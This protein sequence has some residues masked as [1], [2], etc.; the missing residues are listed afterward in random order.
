[1]HAIEA[2]LEQKRTST[3]DD[4]ETAASRLA[5]R[6]A[7]SPD[8]EPD[9]AYLDR[10]SEYEAALREARRYFLRMVESEQ[11]I[12]EAGE[13]LLDNFYVIQQAA[14]QV[15]ENLPAGYYRR[16]PVWETEEGQGEPRVYDLACSLL[17]RTDALLDIERIER[18][19]HAYQETKTLTMGEL[20]A[21]PTIL[22]LAVLELLARSSRRL[23]EGLAEAERASAPPP[24]DAPLEAVV[25]RCVRSLHVIET[26]DWKA[27]FEEASRVEGVLREDPAGVYAGMDFETRDAYRQVVEKL[28]RSS[29]RDEESVAREALRLAE[30]AEGN[31]GLRRAAHIGFYL[32]GRG[33]RQLETRLDYRPAWR[34]RPRRW[35]LERPLPIYLGAIGLLTLLILAG[36][37]AYAHAAGGTPVG[38]IGA[39][40]LGLAPALAA[41]V[42]LVNALVTR[43]VPPRTLPKLDL[44]EGV[45]AEQTT[46]VVIPSML[47][48]A[49]E[50]E[51]LLDQL[52][53]HYL[54]NVDPHLHFALLTDWADAPEEHMPGD[55]E[56]V[57]QA[58]EGIRALNGKYRREGAGPFYLFHRRRR[59][60]PGESS[61]MGWERKRGKL[62]EFNR[63]LLDRG[64]TSYTVQM[65]DLEIL[66]EI[67]Y[68][69]TLDADTV[70]PRDSARRLIATLAHPLNRPVFAPDGKTVTAG[71]TVL[72]PRVEVKPTAV[73]RSRFTRIFAGDAGVDLYTRA[74]SDVYHDLFGEGIYVGKGIY[75]VETFQHSLAGRVPDNTILSHDLFEGIQGR[76]GLVS[77]VILYED[78]PPDYLSYMRRLH[79]WVRGDW[80]LLPWLLP[81]A[82]HA[83]GSKVPN[84][85]SLLDRWKIV[86]NLRRSLHA[87]ALLLWLLVG[88][89][90]LPGSSLAWT[91]LVLLISA[92]SL[93]TSLLTNAA[94][95]LVNGGTSETGSSLKTEA[96]RWLLSLVFLPYEALLMIDA[97]G[98]T[99]VRMLVSRKRLLQW[100]TAAHTIRLFGREKKL[101]IIWRQ[102]QSAVLL[103]LGLAV[104]VGVARPAALSTAA[105]FLLAWLASPWVAL[106][107]SRSIARKR[108]ELSAE[109]RNRLRRLARRTWLY[110]ERFIGPEDHWL[111]P[112]H[113][114]EDPRGV[115][116]HRTSPT[117]IGLALLSTL[118]AY[119]L[120]YVGLLD[121]TIRLRS[122]FEN[123][124]ELERHRGHFLNWYNTRNLRPL[125]PRYVSTV[126]SGN[127]AGC[128]LALRQ[129]L[130]ALSQKPLLRP[131]RWQGL[132]DILDVLSEIVAQVEA[133]DLQKEASALSDHLASLRRR[134]AESQGQPGRWFHTLTD[135]SDDD[136]RKLERL[137]RSLT[138][139]GKPGLSAA[140]LRDLQIWSARARYHLKSMQKEIDLL[141]PW[142]KAMEELPPLLA[143][144]DGHP[145]VRE[146]WQALGST[147]SA[148]DR[149][150]DVSSVCRVGRA[151]LADLQDALDD[152]AATFEGDRQAQAAAVEQILQARRWCERLG[153]LL[154][155]ARM[156]VSA[157]L[158]G[159]RDLAAQAEAYVGAMDFRFLF[160]P[161]HRVF[162]LGWRVD[163][164]KLD[165]HRYDLLVSEARIASL[166]AIA[167]GDIPHN[168]WLYLN[169]PLARVNGQRMLLSWNGSMFEYLMPDLLIRNYENTL[170]DQTDR[171]AIDGQIAYARQASPDGSIPWGI[172]ESG[173]YHFD[174]SMNYQYRGFGVPGLG[175]KR[176]LGQDLVITPYASLLALSLSPQ[177]VVE[178]VNHLV[179]ERMLGRYGFYE[180]VDYTPSRMPMG[181]ERAIVR[182][183]MAHHQG[184]ILVALTNYL[185][186]EPIVDFFH[187]DP[188]IQ[189]VE[190][191]LQERV[192]GHA[193]LEELP[194]EPVDAEHR[195]QGQIALP[196]WDAPVHSPVPSVHFLSNGRYGT[197]I[198]G[199]G[200]GYSVYAPSGSGAV[201]PMALTRW[202]ADTAQDGWGTWIY[203]QGREGASGIHD[204]PWSVGF[205]PTGVTPSEQRVRFY[206][207]QAEF[208]RQDR[209]ISVEMTISVAPE[210]DVEV[211]SITLIN[212]GERAHELALTSYA[213]V[214]LAPQATDR[215]HPAFNKLF[216]ESE[217]L[218][219]MALLLFR[220]R[221]S[222]SEETP[223]YMGHMLIA[224]RAG[225]VSVTC[226]SDRA[227]FLGRGR[228]TRQPAALTSPTAAD[229]AQFGR[230]SGTTGATLDP[231]MALVGALQVEAHE[232]VELAY[233][234]LAAESR[235]KILELARRYR[236]WS[237]IA[238]TFDDAR[239]QTQVELRNLGLD[240]A[241]VEQIQ[242]L[243][244]VLLYPHVALRADPQ[245]LA[246]NSQAQSGLWAFGISGDH[247]ILLVRV[248]EETELG[249]VREALQAHA[250]W[251]NRQV[252]IDLVIL[253]VKDAGYAQ[254]LGDQV[255]RVITQTDNEAWLNRRG[256][257]FV[258]RV[259]QMSRSDR[260]L[261]ETAARAVLDGEEGRLADQLRGLYRQ[262]TR[263]PHFAPSPRVSRGLPEGEESH[264]A[265]PDDLEFDNGLGGFSPDGREYVIYLEPGQ[266]T[267]APWIN[268]IANSQFGFLVS[269]A[270]AGYTW[271]GN[272][273]E[274]RLTPWRNDPVADRP[275]EALYLRDE[276]TAD[277]WSPTRL[278]AGAD[279]PYLIRHGAGYSIFEHHSHGLDQ[280]LR[281]FA[282]R[283]DPVKIVQLR[284]ENTLDRNRR[285]TA[286]FYA[287]WVLGTDRETQQ[288]ILPEYD[289]ETTALLAR[290][291]Y[292]AEFDRRVAFLVASQEPHG[293]TADRAE[294]LGR[295]LSYRLP[296]ALE[297]VGLSSTV[298]PGLDPC[299]AIQIHIN[300]EPGETKEV[301]FLLGQGADRDDTLRLVR[302]YRDVERIDR[303]WAEA[304]G[305]WDDYLSTVA[306]QTPDPA[307][308]LLLNRWLPYQALSCRLWARSAL[309]QSSGAYG[310]RDQLQDVT[311]VLHAAPELAREH[312]L[313]S[314]RHQFEA[315][316]VLHWWQPPADRGVRTRITDDLLWLP[317][318]TAEY[319]DAT[320]DAA[321]LDEQEPFRAGEPLSEDETERYDHYPL[322]EE[323]FSVY[324][325]CCR[326]L[327]RG[328]TAGPRGLP[329][330][331]AG[332]WNDGM[333][334]VG[335]GGQGE[336]VWLGW[337]L[338]AAL[339]R[340]APLCE[341]RGDGE[342]A[343]RYR[344]HAE[345]LRAALET[346]GWDGAWYR[347]AYYDD[348]TPLGSAQSE[349]CQ[350]AS[351]PQS[352]AVLSGAA[353]EERAAEAMGA[354][355]ERLVRPDDRLILLFAPPFDETPR[356]P[357]YIKGYPPGVRENG[358]QYTHAALWAVWAFARLGQGDR[359]GEL[360]RLLNP[361]YYADTPEKV[362]RYCVEPYVVA[363]DVYSAESHVGRGGWTWYT[364]SSGWMYRVGLEAIL[365]LR[366]AGDRL[367]IAPCISKDW[368]GYEI[369]YRYGESVYRIQVE[370]PDGVSQGVRQVTLDGEE[371]ADG[372][373]PLA[374][375]GEEHRVRVLMGAEG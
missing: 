110:F 306:V 149:L 305:F 137:L 112:D 138:N 258:L 207:H 172:S 4:L 246:E 221:L 297:R 332:D 355:E 114:Q 136:W 60:N 353:E 317:Y 370:N 133:D 261:L 227:R 40:V 350:I 320:G 318:V 121:L 231:I 13:W 272:S 205:Q 182:S 190:M 84:A 35:L 72:Q 150:A 368:P 92:T 269:E 343:Q 187:A 287:E 226:E 315:G 275:G 139:S 367:R 118:S 237:Q 312:I 169:R 257:I 264:L 17:E 56:L 71:Y 289:A 147:L 229:E 120:G 192:P 134:V 213:E 325:H 334:R 52:E 10:L 204:E 141:S 2:V 371:R 349:E 230:L 202:R 291:T 200:G 55:G 223:L 42:N 27:F 266:W 225:D 38:W 124:D 203:V 311:A 36:V 177:R 90:G 132:L 153:E 263:L 254:E 247:P 61:W 85:L 338:Y 271:A 244:S 333:N 194:R 83:A 366:R 32:L 206:P 46:M 157:L 331:G 344:G 267:P 210:D 335:V 252:P 212:H 75:D 77:D 330:I 166:V 303:A 328:T 33:R 293:L 119:E 69:I 104:L 109:E 135:L 146:A 66:P 58:K 154:D 296:A 160:D 197:L 63:L 67:R 7:L 24:D 313:R 152:Y 184:M 255:H 70:L 111:P 180:A 88:W 162:Y 347:R 148:V 222:S 142:L 80:Q 64:E 65:G 278:P 211:R 329:R 140:T 319:V 245:T 217:Y 354:V 233:V 236:S 314:A 174:A 369:V 129:G 352:W 30:E 309:Y 122:T 339:T 361:I 96:A 358:G 74:V 185:M 165:D 307:M 87:P 20:W 327:E 322:T 215:R 57:E 48:S 103:A 286:T 342:R 170:L 253:N 294:F 31:D 277:V 128:L 113:F 260:L 199:A 161:Q 101:P 292:S 279:A 224:R 372:E 242:K 186:D 43:V 251:R 28:A 155:G 243:L 95:R 108:V 282:A 273:G 5:E 183:Y 340:F 191:L 144:A 196:S 8:L 82:P 326:A 198:T 299:A 375:D 18:F 284:L 9:P 209:D 59:W 270:G 250:Y 193:P 159:V 280:R 228:T 175:R 268:V 176:G 14:R 94:R 100:T 12:P 241:G 89:I 259:H 11:V 15:R 324:E 107:I 356:D 178:N 304:T 116:A 235:E 26:E 171:A 44:S 373:I 323:T 98:T 249:L 29:D 281:L 50:V 214:V 156:T 16:L 143:H 188:R 97:I 3:G 127:L 45:P 262:P 365:G 49:D 265:R 73:N 336:S 76:S 300:L 189:S 276:E 131:E 106:W 158:I 321:I 345:E 308:D 81:H 256:G 216:I 359:A 68:V 79:R 316:D 168:H 374:D 19:I 288:Y 348:G 234:T 53:Q 238:R 91:L 337:F 301:F 125:A 363:P 219:D 357:G 364:G 123:M 99:L 117:N 290:N 78:Y 362:R 145:A 37:G 1:M 54:S 360:F 295:D 126:D 208:Q 298:E 240:A 39:L 6:H 115:V 285:V 167:K 102:M 51:S 21:W 239:D 86:D 47:T 62:V 248:G 346:Q 23:T 310:F 179:E 283:E 341:R 130:L 151:R 22:R 351:L 181:E 164:G 201:E 302:E 41:A 105:P 25:A 232:T 93:V 163:V 218:P 195:V 274:N 220:R 34:A 173:Y